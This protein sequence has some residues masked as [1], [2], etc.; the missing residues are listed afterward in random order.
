MSQD[1]HYSMFRHYFQ[2]TWAIAGNETGMFRGHPVEE[3]AN[4]LVENYFSQNLSYIEIDAVLVLNVWMATIHELQEVTRRCTSYDKDEALK[5]LDKAVALWIGGTPQQSESNTRGYLLYSQAETIGGH[6]GQVDNGEAL[7]NQRVLEFFNSLQTNLYSDFSCL[8]GFENGMI[9]EEM[10]SLVGVMTIPLIQ[11]LIH[12]IMNADNEGRSDFIELYALSVAPRVAACNPNLEDF[13]GSLNVSETADITEKHAAI[14][15]LQSI[16]SCLRVSCDDIGTYEGVLMPTCGN[17]SVDGISLAGY[18][19]PRASALRWSYLDRDILQIR[20]LMESR[21]YEAALDLYMYGHNSDLS[22][23]QLALNEAIPHAALSP[24]DLFRIYYQTDTYSFVDS[25]IIT[26]LQLKSPYNQASPD[27]LTELV[28]GLLKYV[29]VHLSVMAALHFAVEEC[30]S[31][32][33][34]SALEYWDIGVA[35]FIGSIEGSGLGGQQSGQLLYA[36]AKETCGQFETCDRST[37]DAFV[38]QM[39]VDA[40]RIAMIS[41]ENSDCQS[42]KTTMENQIGKKIPIPLIQGTLSYAFMNDG[43]PV[44]SPDGIL[45]TGFAYAQSVLPYIHIVSESNAVLIERNMALQFESA[46]VADGFLAVADVFRGALVGMGIDCSDIGTLGARGFCVGQNATFATDNPLPRADLAFGRYNFT[47]QAMSELY[48]SFALDIR[49][50][51]QANTINDAR[52]TYR[53]GSNALGLD[54]SQ[55]ATTLNL[56][57]LSIDAS[58]AMSQDP[59]FNIFKFALYDEATLDVADNFNYADEAVTEALDVRAT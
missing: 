36:T 8:P 31:H 55:V 47:A 6:F 40:L 39:I 17:D 12:H 4:T 25:K 42:V 7:V 33:T 28:V 49:D 53:Y 21:A 5:A 23:Q 59:M 41:L 15:V 22:L 27:Q 43:L 50:I 16:Y 2:R 13:I 58:E 57:S 37:S 14:T 20:I 26:A 54:S 9:R 45:A 18:T 46:P 11:N 38:N 29:V 44:G 48:S 56:A 51:V 1:V 24:F 30:W 34:G 3:Y 10:Q 35:L 32:N 19:S 52:I